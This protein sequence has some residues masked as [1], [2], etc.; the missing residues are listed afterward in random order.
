MRRTTQEGGVEKEHK[1][2][3]KKRKER[4][5]ENKIKN[6]MELGRGWSETQF[7]VLGEEANDV[8]NLTGDVSKVSVG[9]ERTVRIKG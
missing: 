1:R 5:E 2:K 4:A 6:K 3:G 7:E 9:G 8:I